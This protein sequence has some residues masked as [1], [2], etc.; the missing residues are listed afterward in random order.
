MATTTFF[1]VRHGQSTWNVA[2]VI[3][4]HAD[5]AHLTPQGRDQAAAAAA[6]LAQK[7]AARV[8]TSDLARAAQTAQIIAD[9][10]ALPLE[11]DAG[12][13][14]RHYGALEG[15]HADDVAALMDDVIEGVIVD[16][17]AH[18]GGG[19]SL[20]EFLH[21]SR[22]ALARLARRYPG[23]RIIAVTHGG[24]IRVLRAAEETPELVGAH[25]RTVPNAEVWTTEVES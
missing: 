20:E 23:E 13:R 11:V 18:P 8:V 5:D 17:T 7:G 3:Q 4:G 6:V 2:R 12:L 14:E 10:L 15:R 24:V 25:W 19:E 1:L 21:R 22:D 16:A 9:A